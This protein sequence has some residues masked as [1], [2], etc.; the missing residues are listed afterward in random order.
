MTTVQLKDELYWSAV[1]SICSHDIFYHS[2]PTFSFSSASF[3]GLWDQPFILYE[4][5]N[6][7]SST[8]T[9]HT[10]GFSVKTHA[11]RKG[12]SYTVFYEAGK[13]L[14]CLLPPL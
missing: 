4:M 11:P 8:V 10:H 1:K 14:R 13:A 7:F 12:D 6:P 2:W 5:L 3:V 9:V